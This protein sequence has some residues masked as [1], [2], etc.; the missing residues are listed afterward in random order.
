MNR[1]ENLPTH[2]LIKLKVNSHFFVS[3]KALA[4]VRHN[5]KKAFFFYFVFLAFCS[6][7]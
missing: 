5:N 3:R 6:W 1:E 2:A 4:Q 7:C